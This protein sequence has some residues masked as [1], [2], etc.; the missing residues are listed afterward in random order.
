MIETLIAEISARQ[1]FDSRANPTVA[2]TV[3]LACGAVGHA[4]VPSGAS[5]GSHE[6]HELRDGGDSF[7][8]KG[9]MRAVENINTEIAEHLRGKR[10]ERQREIDSLMISLDGSENKSR[11]GANA[12]LAVSL[13]CARAAANACC[14][15][16]FR[17]LGGINACVMPVPMMNILNG[18][19]HASNNLDIQEFMIA[20]RGARSFF[21]AMK[22]GTEVYHSLAKLLRSKGLTTAVG[23]EG[24]FAPDLASDREALELLCD[25]ITAAGYRPGTDISIALD[26]AASEWAC[27]GGYRLPK[28]GTTMTTA[29]LIA[30][31]SELVSS[32][33]I[34][35]IEDPLG[36]EDFEGFASITKQ[37]SGVQ[38]VGDDLFVTNSHRLLR[39]IES[40]SA[41]AILIK[42]N[43]AGTLTETLDAI[44]LAQRKGYG[45]IVSHRSGETEDSTIADLAVAVNCGQIK[46][47]APARSERT[48]KY[49]RLLEIEQLVQKTGKDC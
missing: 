18:G 4:A 22:M 6:A 33:P 17:Y 2:A 29:E 14:V 8:G 11:L 49:N 13:A 39:G 5:T 12:M 26:A 3:E 25:A 24:G 27:D 23:D 16:L 40:N 45:V 10:A 47:G 9:V 41:N 37:L 35:S 38:I 7:G 46:T 28:S 32:Y 34:F 21:E 36:E 20:P 15:P 43:Q 1:I 42:P 48:A 19:A 31:F 44:R 30:H